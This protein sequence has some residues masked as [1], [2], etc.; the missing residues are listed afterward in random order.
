VELPGADG[1]PFS[2]SAPVVP[3]RAVRVVFGPGSLTRVATEARTLGS[4]I[5]IISGITRPLPPGR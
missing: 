4:R 3:D 5:M 1:Q 2:F